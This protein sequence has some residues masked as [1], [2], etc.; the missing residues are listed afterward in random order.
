[1][2]MSARVKSALLLLISVGIGMLLGA[3]L[4]ARLAE[5]RLERLA[6]L[7]TEMGLARALERIV[8]PTD[9]AQRQAIQGVLE[10][11][12]Q[13]MAAHMRQNRERS[14]A[15]LDSTMQALHAVLSD[16][17]IEQLNEQMESWRERMR[18]RRDGA[19]RQLPR[20]RGPPPQP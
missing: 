3:L 5:Q 15:L 12:V 1:M 19:R 9:E 17:Q 20:W 18:M 16:E 14:V 4:Q 7:R 2:A 8:E 11:S 10:S 6:L 13:N